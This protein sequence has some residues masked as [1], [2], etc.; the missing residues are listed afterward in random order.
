MPAA[1]GGVHVGIA[2]ALAGLLRAMPFH[3]RAGRRYIPADIADRTGLD[4]TDYRGCAHP[5]IALGTAEL[6][7]RPTS[8]RSARADRAEVPRAALPAL[9]PAIVAQRSLAT[10]PCRLRPVR[11]GS[12]GPGPSAE[13]AARGRCAVQSLL[14][15]SSLYRPWKSGRRR[16]AI[17]LM[18]SLKSSVR[19]SQS[20]STSSRS[21]AASIASHKPAP[22]RLAGRHHRQRRRLRDLERQCLGGAAHLG[23]RHQHIGEARSAP[24][25]RRGCGG[26]CRTAV[27]PAA[28][29]P[30]AAM[31]RSGR[32][33]DESRA[34]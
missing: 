28:R 26:R 9:L 30:A 6:P 12:G 16:S 8:P 29:R 31:S 24:P 2:Y 11:P 14:K 3:A 19:R 33:R 25:R 7:R 17:A 1:R 10:E 34:G 13:L 4:A 21:V 23:E 22:H 5:G 18:P 20:C 15:L 27:P 32:S